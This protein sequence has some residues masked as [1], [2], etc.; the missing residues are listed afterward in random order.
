M[1]HNQVIPLR[2]PFG[3][4]HPISH[5]ILSSPHLIIYLHVKPSVWREDGYIKIQVKTFL[6]KKI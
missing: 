6:N 2:T 4:P 5:Y 1:K 3:R